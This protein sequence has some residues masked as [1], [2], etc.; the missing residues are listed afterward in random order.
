MSRT[1]AVPDTVYVVKPL[2]AVR[3]VLCVCPHS[4]V[5]TRYLTSRPF[6]RALPPGGLWVT[7]MMWV[8]RFRRAEVSTS[9]SQAT[10]PAFRPPEWRQ[11]NSQLLCVKAKYSRPNRFRKLP[12]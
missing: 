10:C 1:F 12:R 7:T 5:A 2:W 3:L 11:T 4:T 9:S 6:S 8:R